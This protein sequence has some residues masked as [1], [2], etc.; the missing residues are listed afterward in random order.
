MKN[1]TVIPSLTLTVIIG[2]FTSGIKCQLYINEFLASNATIIEDPDYGDFA[3]WLEIFNAGAA[4]IN[5]NGYYITDN[6]DNP[7][8]WRIIQNIYNITNPS[9][10]D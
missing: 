5:L 3:D 1:K 9:K 4:T 8:K 10:H 7:E 2:L 6:L